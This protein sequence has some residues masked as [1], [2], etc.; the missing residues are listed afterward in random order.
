MQKLCNIDKTVIPRYFMAILYRLNFSDIA[1]YYRKHF[2]RMR[3]KTW[4]SKSLFTRNNKQYMVLSII[5]SIIPSKPF[6]YTTTMAVLLNKHMYS[7]YQ[8]EVVFEILTLKIPL[9]WSFCSDSHISYNTFHT[10][11]LV[12]TGKLWLLTGQL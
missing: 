12:G 1:Q 9:Y 2:S 5:D 8:A 10:S 11:C 3:V 6:K 4:N 7:K